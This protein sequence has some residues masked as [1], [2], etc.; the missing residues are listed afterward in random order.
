MNILRT[1]QL[2][3]VMEHHSQLPGMSQRYSWWGIRALRELFRGNFELA[4]L[5]LRAGAGAKTVQGG[6]KERVLWLPC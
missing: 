4:G 3:F 5:Y 2:R 1:N 6:V